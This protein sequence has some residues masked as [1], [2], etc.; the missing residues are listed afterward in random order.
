MGDAHRGPRSL[1]SR[2]AVPPA[3][4]DDEEL[5]APLGP[6]GRLTSRFGKKRRQRAKEKAGR[7][8]YR[9]YEAGKPSDASQGG[10]RAAVYKGEMGASHRRFSRMQQKDSSRS[11]RV[12]MPEAKRPLFARAPFVVACATVLCLGLGAAFLYGPAQQLYTDIRERDR[13]AAEYEAVTERNA[14]IEAQVEALSTEAGIEDAARTQL[15]WVHEGEH[16]VSVSGLAEKDAT[17]EF[18]GNI[19]SEDIVAPDTWYSDL[20]DPLFGVG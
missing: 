8:Y 2:G 4:I 17:S 13:L 3:D 1:E 5:E 16:A 20:L 7:A 12:K 9:Q 18:R 14:A 10:P 11:G 19:V 15:G 6:L